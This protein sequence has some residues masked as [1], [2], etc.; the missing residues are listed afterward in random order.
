MSKRPI[1]FLLNDDYSGVSI[2]VTYIVMFLNK[3]LF[4][5][6]IIMHHQVDVDKKIE[7][8]P[9][10]MAG[11][12]VIKIFYSKYENLY[13][14]ARRLA[15]LAKFDNKETFLFTNDSHSLALLALLKVQN[16]IAF[17]LHGDMNYYYSTALKFQNNINLYFTYSNKVYTKLKSLLPGQLNNIHKVYYPYPHSN[18]KRFKNTNK[19]LRVLYAG[20]L[21]NGH[22]GIFDL[23]KIDQMLKQNGVLVKWHII[24]FGRDEDELKER[25]NSAENVEWIGKVDNKNVLKLCSA[26]DLIV[27]PSRVEGLPVV[28]VEAMK[29]GLIPLVTDI[30]SGY[31]D[32]ITDGENGFILPVGDIKAFSDKITLLHVNREKL[33]EMSINS[34]NSITLMFNPQKNINEFERLINGLPYNNFSKKPYIKI[35]SKLD[36][37]YLP[38]FLVKAIRK[39]IGK[40]IS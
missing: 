17:M 1:Y 4:D 36:S 25:W 38:N 28:L 19:R 34:L 8:H 18:F 33:E 26:N 9:N 27:L 7:R 40:I 3:D 5:V 13:S 29:V 10:I 24:G 12:P 15:K 39:V 31:P 2:I 23:P 35:G 37:K 32:V 11:L 14:V 21:D 16:P 30:D 22:K 20:R 6:T